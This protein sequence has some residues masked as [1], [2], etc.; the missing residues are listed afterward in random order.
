MF[1]LNIQNGKLIKSTNTIEDACFSL[2]ETA[3]TDDME[4]ITFFYG[5]NIELDEVNSVVDKIQ[6]RYPDHEIE[7]HEG[8]QPHYQFII[9]IE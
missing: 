8:G 1:T 3:N 9:A 7:L 5:N 6:K 4:R 2:L